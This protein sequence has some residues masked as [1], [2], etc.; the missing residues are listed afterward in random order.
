VILALE[1]HAV[2][3]A[4]GLRE[5]FAFLLVGQGL[6]QLVGGPD[7]EAALLALAVGVS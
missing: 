4:V 3:G 6:R 1:V 5:E 2:G 7:V